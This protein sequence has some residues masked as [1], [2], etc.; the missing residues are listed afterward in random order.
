MEFLTSA[1]KA[2]PAISTSPL[3]LIGFALTLAA[4]VLAVFRAKRM[5]LLLQRLADIPEADRAR[6]IQLELG[7]ILP[8]RISAQ[9]WIRARSHRYYLVA[10]LA[11]LVTVSVI[12]T[13]AM[14]Q[15]AENARIAEQERSR[16]AQLEEK[17]QVVQRKRDGLESRLQSIDQNIAVQEDEYRRGAAGLQYAP[18][19]QKELALQIMRNAAKTIADL[20]AERQELQKQIDALPTI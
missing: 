17:R 6:V 14:V 13:I 3:A 15:G 4:W 12:G 10:F 16:Q 20:K 7:E 1:L 5:K 19:D 2:I 11:L 8:A 9:Q 18:I